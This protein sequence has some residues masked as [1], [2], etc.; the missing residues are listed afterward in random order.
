MLPPGLVSQRRGKVT[1]KMRKPRKRGIV[2]RRC[3]ALRKRGSPTEDGR[4]GTG[5]RTRKN[6]M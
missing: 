5:P 6:G 1:E 4:R 3:T 2:R